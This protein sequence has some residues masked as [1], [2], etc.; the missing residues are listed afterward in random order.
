MFGKKEELSAFA[1]TLECGRDMAIEQMWKHKRDPRSFYGNHI[2]YDVAVR[3]E[4]TGQPTFDAHVK[5]PGNEVYL[6][7]TGV[8]LHVKF[9]PKSRQVSYDDSPKDIR[10]RNPQL[11]DSEWQ[12]WLNQLL[13]QETGRR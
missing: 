6:L 4:P 3:V 9:E 8:R 12:S 11:V 5:V 1:V 10:A 13:Q 2:T 7:S